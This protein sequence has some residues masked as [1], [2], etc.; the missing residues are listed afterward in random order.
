MFAVGCLGLANMW[1][2]AAAAESLVLSNRGE[3][4]TEVNVLADTPDAA[5][6]EA[7]RKVNMWY[8]RHSAVLI[9]RIGN[10]DEDPQDRILAIHEAALLRNPE[11]IDSLLA[12]LDLND[13]AP[14]E[15]YSAASQVLANFGDRRAIEP[16][17]SVKKERDPK[18]YLIAY[19]AL[20]S[21]KG[22]DVAA[23]LMATE[24]DEG[25]LRNDAQLNLLELDR[26]LATDVLIKAL[27][28][29]KERLNRRF[30][31]RALA[32]APSPR[33]NEA[34]IYSLNDPDRRTRRFA[35]LT[36][37]QLGV[38]EALPHLFFHMELGDV[39]PD[40]L[41]AIQALTGQ[42]FGYRLQDTPL[43]RR[44]ATNRAFAWWVQQENERGY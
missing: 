36:L 14:L 23:S 8:I 42:D 19:N 39:S 28:D 21:I 17:K 44:A 37:A 16:W 6:I 43:D 32:Q 13:P 33:T 41:I 34:L 40:Y 11:A 10:K 25:A 2:S 22:F 27:Q 29:D 5:I 9:E 18:R 15:V 3:Q 31:A 4:M 1:T 24:A 20:H 35:A 30:A 26:E 7:A 38:Q 12:L